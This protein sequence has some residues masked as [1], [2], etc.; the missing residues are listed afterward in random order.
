MGRSTAAQVGIHPLL[1][2]ASKA[3]TCLHGT[4]LRYANPRQLHA[5][6]DSSSP[7]NTSSLS[8]AESVPSVNLAS[9]QLRPA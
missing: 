6:L 1:M 9:R 5:T 7:M 3:L 4:P 2:I 8:L